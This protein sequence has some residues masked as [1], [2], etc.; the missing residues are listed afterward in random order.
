MIKL[1]CAHTDKYAMVVI[2]WIAYVV[3]YVERV[4]VNVVI[5]VNNCYI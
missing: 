1:I 3:D 4:W 2:L 5:S